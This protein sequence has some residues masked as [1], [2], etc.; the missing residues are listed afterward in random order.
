LGVWDKIDLV[1][2]PEIVRIKSEK[3]EFVVPLEDPEGYIRL[4]SQR[5]P[6]EAEGIRSFVN[7]M[8]GIYEETE[9]YGR[10]RGYREKSRSV[11]IYD[12]LFEGYSAPGTSTLMRTVAGI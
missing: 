4:L 11:S 8:I 5:F 9:D 10:K 12:N 1:K 3:E 7:E 6:L 2:L